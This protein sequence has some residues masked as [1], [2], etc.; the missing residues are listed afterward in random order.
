MWEKKWSPYSGCTWFF[1]HGT[2]EESTLPPFATRAVYVAEESF[3]TLPSWI[4]FLYD[5]YCAP[6]L[7]PFPVLHALA[8]I[9]S[10]ATY[11][12]SPSWLLQEHLLCLIVTKPCTLLGKLIDYF[13]L[14]YYCYGPWD[15]FPQMLV[16]PMSSFIF[17]SK[18]GQT[19]LA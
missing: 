3:P 1:L 19:E 12:S 14:W 4:F 10:L 16:L 2:G 11:S 5:L 13:P 9:Y 8:P 17:F 18:K 7:V 15:Y 6:W